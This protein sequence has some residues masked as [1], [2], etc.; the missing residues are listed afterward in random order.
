MDIR[1]FAMTNPQE[2]IIQEQVH[3]IRAPVQ[4]LTSGSGF[5]TAR[6]GLS[7]AARREHRQV[8]KKR[9]G[10]YLRGLVY[11]LTRRQ[12]DRGYT[13]AGRME[14]FHMAVSLVRQI[15]QANASGEAA[16]HHLH[17]HF[18]HDPTLVAQLAHQ[19]T[20]ITY[21][22]TA[23]ARD[24]FQVHRRVLAER[25]H[26]A[27]AVV[28]CCQNNLGYLEHI[29]PEARAKF[30][31]IYHG[32][33]L[34]RFQ[35][36]DHPAETTPPLILS[37]GRLVE[38]KG[39]NDLLAALQKVQERGLPFRCLI[40]GDGPLGPDIDRWIGERGLSGRVALAGSCTQQELLAVF[41]SAALF[42]LT[43]TVTEDG[44]R[45]GIPNVLVE[46]MA[47]GLPV[48]S[49]ITAGIPELVTH[50]LNGLLYM[51]HDVD[52]IAAGIGDLLQDEHKR[53]R[54][55]RAA[56]PRVT[57]QFDLALAAC[58]LKELFSQPVPPARQVEFSRADRWA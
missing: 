9:P 44:D 38:K 58:Q 12:I 5:L 22:F 36:P 55:G 57:E 11:A 30:S 6:S 48:I 50:N 51:P 33:N 53:H 32:V 19:I 42:V 25:I 10:G 18:A 17:A 14:C 24:L 27:S 3:E 29:A 31:M 35:P 28:T 26:S 21:S 1:I 54:L 7:P 15:E 2:E 8:F 39:F 4:Y 46:A 13:A 41:Q 37:V 49:T 43:P 45:D 52:G 16:I 23:H 34:Q 20:G 40:Y 56:R 47:V